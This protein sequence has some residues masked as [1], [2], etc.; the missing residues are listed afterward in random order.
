MKNHV[1]TAMLQFKLSANVVGAL[2]QSCWLLH[3]C[4][5][6]VSLEQKLMTANWAANYHSF[7]TMLSPFLP[8]TCAHL[9]GGYTQLFSMCHKKVQVPHQA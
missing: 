1:C 3:T 6:M 8:D 4:P 7:A 5:R 2:Q 9:L